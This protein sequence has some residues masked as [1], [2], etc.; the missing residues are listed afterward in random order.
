MLAEAADLRAEADDFHG[1][2]ASLDE[3]TWWQPTPFKGWTPFDV[4]AHLHSGDNAARLAV[5]DPEAFQ[6]FLAARNAKPKPAQE[7]ERVETR[8]PRVLLANWRTTLQE[9][10]E[11]L[12]EMPPDARIAW[13]GPPLSLRTFAAARLMEVWA[14]AQDVYD[15]LRRP[16]VHH[17]R[18]RAI[19]ELGVRTYGFSFTNRG[20]KMPETKP[21]VRLTAPSGAV[22]EWN[23]PSESDCITG[24][25]VEFCQ[26]VTQGRNIR[27][28][29]L[30][31]VGEA[32]AQ[33]MGVAQ[34]FA[35]APV[36]PPRP[37]ERAW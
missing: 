35:G 2:L 22:W 28:T 3:R 21:Y 14:H 26:V 8:D 13:V 31:V 6:R 18:I 25:A 12:G 15:L 29:K 10:A 32:A 23:P 19:A 11:R 4:V 17:D 16:R 36:D 33:W 7:R 30:E 5:E 37:G 20:R 9:L 1:L 34:C 27:D 24:S